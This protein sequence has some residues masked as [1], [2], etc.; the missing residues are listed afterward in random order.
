MAQP[1]TLELSMRCVGNRKI[2]G[3]HHNDLR[4]ICRQ[5]FTAIVALEPEKETDRISTYGTF[6]DTVIEQ[7]GTDILFAGRTPICTAASVGV[8]V[9]EQGPGQPQH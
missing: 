9:M 6:I 8:P 4:L 7:S 3:S 1:I 5:V 2:S